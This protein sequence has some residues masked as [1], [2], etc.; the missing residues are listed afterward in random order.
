M[1]ILYEM[2]LVIGG[3]TTLKSLLTR[4]LQRLLYHTSFPTGL[5]LLDLPFDAGAATAKARLHT[6]IG[7][8]ELD[9][10]VEHMMELPAALLYGGAELREDA[11]LLQALPCPSSPYTTFLRLPVG[12]DGVILL[13]AQATP[14]TE[15]PFTRIFQPVMGNLAKAILLCRRN[16]AYTSELVAERNLAQANLRKAI[17]AEHALRE[18]EE[19]FRMITTA[20]RDAIIMV[21]GA[22]RIACWNPAAEHFLGYGH[23]E[24]MGRD[25]RAIIGEGSFHEAYERFRSAGEGSAADESI[26]LTAVRKDGSK[27][28]VEVSIS[29]IRLGG[30]HG[31]VGILRDITERKRMEAQIAASLAEKEVLVQSLNE[32]ATRDG[33]TGLCNHRAFYTL[34]ADELARVRRFRRPVS[35]LLLDIDHFKRINDIH[36]HLA[37]DATLRELGKLLPREVRG[38]DHVCRYGGEEITLI[39]PETDIEAAARVAERLR[40]TVEAQPFEVNSGAPLHITVSIGIASWPLHADVAEALVA[41]ADKALYAAKNAGRNRVMVC[42]DAAAGLPREA[43]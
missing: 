1:A 6:A 21:D 25:L 20:A 32:L 2:A 12:H 10:H 4:T 35:L 30:K 16:E 19:K 7:D 43:G 38:I 29:A 26:E 27:F 11:A 13:L 17:Q 28:P 22:G 34:L 41:A 24:A 31:A 14:R 5:A 18:S 8:S 42:Q 39:L 37:G 33:L 36:G 15:L 9:A 3:E 40:S 23:E